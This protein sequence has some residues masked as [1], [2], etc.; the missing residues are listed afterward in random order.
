M[1]YNTD[2]DILFT[3]LTVSEMPSRQIEHFG[4]RNLFSFGTLNSIIFEF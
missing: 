1:G 2:I 4:E 3:L